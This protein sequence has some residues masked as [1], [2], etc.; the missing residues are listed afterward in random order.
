MRR[1]GP[2][3]ALLL[4]TSL[5]ALAAAP[6][7][8]MKLLPPAAALPAGWHGA[9][10]AGGAESALDAQI[11]WQMRVPRVLLAFLAGSA[12]SL[13]GMA[14]QALFRNPLA[15]P[16]TLGVSSGAAFGAAVTIWLGVPLLGGVTPAL[17]SFAGAGLS[18]LLVWGLSRAR[19]GMSTAAM[20]L[21][22]VA[23]SFFFS[24]LILFVQFL[25]DFAGSLRVLHWLM[26]RIEAVGY[27]GVLTLLPFSLVG[28]LVVLSRHRELDLFSAGE[29]L[30]AARGVEV[31]RTRGLLFLAVSLMV[32][33]VVSACGPIGFVGMMVPHVCRLLLGPSHRLLGVASLAGG[34]AFLVFC[35]TLARTV[36]ATAEIPVGVVTSLLGGPFFVWLLVRERTR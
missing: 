25:A 9:G 23:V 32:G 34:G 26:G 17:A 29:E 3:L 15:T 14:F 22:G 16:Y 19:R 27:G 2:L 11:F 33:G 13:A 18:V 21:A 20:L 6:F 12:L 24:S 36:I 30:A 10:G 4:A 31:A 8:G 5:A 1:R 35:D 7:L 28:S